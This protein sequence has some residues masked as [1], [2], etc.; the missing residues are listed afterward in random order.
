MGGFESCLFDFCVMFCLFV[1][2][3]EKCEVRRVGTG[4][5]EEHNMTRKC[6]EIFRNKKEKERKDNVT[7]WG[8]GN[9][10]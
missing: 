5:W 4:T 7:K 9:M 6:S 10:L 1:C 8:G 2:L 3:R